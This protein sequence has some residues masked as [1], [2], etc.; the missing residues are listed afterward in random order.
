[1]SG[2]ADWLSHG[3]G[4]VH[5]AD[6]RPQAAEAEKRGAWQLH[7]LD[8]GPAVDTRLSA[9]YTPGWALASPACLA[10]TTTRSVRSALCV[11]MTR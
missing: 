2:A 6:G 1:M 11:R 9:P 7:L 4:G 5:P 10:T 8:H 3:P